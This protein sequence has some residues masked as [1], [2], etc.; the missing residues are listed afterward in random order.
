MNPDYALTESFF[1]GLRRRVW[2]RTLPL[3]AV[4][5]GAGWYI[6]GAHTD[7]IGIGSIAVMGLVFMPFVTWRTIRRQEESFRT[8]RIK[9]ADGLLIKIQKGFPLVTVALDDITALKETKGKGLLVSGQTCS[10]RIFLPATLEGYSELRALLGNHHVIETKPD[11]SGYLIQTASALAATL[12][13]LVFY[14]ATSPAV[15]VTTGILLIGMLVTCFIIMQKSPHLD[16]RTK[17]AS[18][19]TWLAVISL[20]GRIWQFL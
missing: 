17:A 5:L 15:V 13:L 2:V 9:V 11:T 16:K 6:A 8:L 7:W 12:L 4:A 10:H 20:A 18:W 3:M 1:A 14:L 19:T